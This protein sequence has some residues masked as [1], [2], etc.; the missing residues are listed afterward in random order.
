MYEVNIQKTIFRVII[1][2]IFERYLIKAL[3]PFKTYSFVDE[4]KIACVDND[5]AS[6]P[7]PGSVKQ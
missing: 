5:A 1:Q 2:L 6:D 4:S 3:P 7:L